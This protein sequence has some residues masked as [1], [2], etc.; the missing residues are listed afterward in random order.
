MK[1]R[2]FSIGEREKIQELCWQR[3]SLRKIAQIL[4]RSHSSIVR[5]LRNSSP[6]R[7]YQYKPRLAHERA[8]EKR[9][10]RG[11]KD[12]LKT[13]AIREYVIE[14]LTM[15]WSPE[16]IAGRI[17]RDLGCSISHEAIYQFIYVQVHREGYG[18]L[19]RG[20]IDLRSCLRRRRKRRMRKGSRTSQRILVPHGPSIDLR[21]REVLDRARVGDWESDTIESKD[22]KPGVNTLVERKTGVILITK[23]RTRTSMS[24]SETVIR[25]FQGLS[26]DVRR[27]I[28]FDNGA[29]NQKWEEIEEAIGVSC[30]FTHPYHSWE[31]GTNENANGLIRDYFPKK[32]DFTKISEEEIR[33]VEYDL[34]MRP[35]KRLD[36]LT[37]LEALS[38]ATTG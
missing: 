9:R 2:H 15:R 25:R 31:R 32:T 4:G 36:W 1:Y 27:T 11:R 19:R 29:E 16:Q 18:C 28:T 17:K 10:S 6:G 35:R 33:N 14:H 30:F 5:E 21:P 37:P 8:L 38:G 20:G 24:T 7:A 3:V 26:Q 34:N 22:H 13:A 23:L 12:R